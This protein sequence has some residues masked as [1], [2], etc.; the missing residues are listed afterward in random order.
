MGM[1]QSWAQNYGSA[2]INQLVAIRYLYRI[3]KSCIQKFFCQNK[4]SF[5]YLPKETKLNRLYTPSNALIIEGCMQ[6]FRSVA[7]QIAINVNFCPIKICLTH[8]YLSE[9]E[10]Y[11]FQLASSTQAVQYS[12]KFF[13]I[14][15]SV[16]FILNY[17]K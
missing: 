13:H 9:S 5:G 10:W 4:I 14:T 11:Y 17:P 7:L 1:D 6:N 2:K 3:A 15:E 8:Y 16:V 12:V